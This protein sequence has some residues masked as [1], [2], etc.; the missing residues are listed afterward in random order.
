MPFKAL[1]GTQ[2]MYFHGHVNLYSVQELGISFK[3]VQAPASLHQLLIY[4]T[5][6]CVSWCWRVEDI[7]GICLRGCWVI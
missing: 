5:L 6:P 2:A 3:S 4:N 7:A 1:R